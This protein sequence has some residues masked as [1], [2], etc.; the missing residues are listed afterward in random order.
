MNFPSSLLYT[1]LLTFSWLHAEVLPKDFE[2]T[3]IKKGTLVYQ[4]PFDQESQL[5]GWV[6]PQDHDRG[7]AIIKNK[8]LALICSGT[9]KSYARFKLPKPVNN[10]TTSLLFNSKSTERFTFAYEGTSSNQKK[11]SINILY[12]FSVGKFVITYFD[13]AS[14]DK[15]SSADTPVKVAEARY[16]PIKSEWVRL[17]IDIKDSTLVL[18]VEGKA[19]TKATI[20]AVK[21]EKTGIFLS[22]LQGTVL[23]DDLQI[24]NAK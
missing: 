8:Q 14:K 19:L 5:K 20:D 6:L 2:P 9:E 4:N 7:S 1:F 16:K 3:L 17:R 10:C 21:N 22:S 15:S 11:F 23:I 12:Y 13:E 24:H 18:N